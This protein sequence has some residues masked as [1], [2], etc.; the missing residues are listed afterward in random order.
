MV[1]VGVTIEDNPADGGFSTYYATLDGSNKSVKVNT[2]PT[3]NSLVGQNNPPGKEV[4]NLYEDLEGL[5][6]I[7][8]KVF[9]ISESAFGGAFFPGAEGTDPGVIAVQPDVKVDIRDLQNKGAIAGVKFER[10][11]SDAGFDVLNKNVAYNIQSGDGEDGIVGSQLYKI[12]NLS[13]SKTPDVQKIGE[14]S[15]EL[16]DGLAIINKFVAVASDFEIADNDAKDKMPIPGDD[17]LSIINLKNGKI[18]QEVKVNFLNSK[19]K[20]FGVIDG[21]SGIDFAPGNPE[22]AKGKLNFKNLAAVAK[23]KGGLFAVEDETNDIFVAI[24]SSKKN[25]GSFDIIKGKGKGARLVSD[26]HFVEI[27]DDGLPEQLGAGGGEISEGEFEGLA[28]IDI[29]QGQF[30]SLFAPTEIV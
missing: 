2:I 5:G 12:T 20:S 4:N 3:N 15:T 14:A 24:D 25:F 13:S 21:D 17:M 30:N 18:L 19:G 23:V 26:I 8:N 16:A 7:G 22:N 27:N 1:L 10:L 11:G 9:A 28:V 6:A 29:P